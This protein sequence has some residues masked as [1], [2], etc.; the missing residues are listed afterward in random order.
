MLVRV[1]TEKK[2]FSLEKGVVWKVCLKSQPKNN[3]ANK[4]LVKELSK[5]YKSVRI[6]SG[7]RSK[8]KTLELE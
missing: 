7:L 6:V 2:S 1:R 8:T 5:T 3:L 4:E